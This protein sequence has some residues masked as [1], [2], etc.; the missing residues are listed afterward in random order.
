MYS[1]VI[2]PLY[3]SKYKTG[4]IF[5]EFSKYSVPFF[6]VKYFN[7]RDYYNAVVKRIRIEEA[8]KYTTKYK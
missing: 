5:C 2:T 1:R 6:C 8:W 4:N 7:F 3:I